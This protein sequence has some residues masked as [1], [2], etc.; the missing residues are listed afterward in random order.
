MTKDDGMTI[1]TPKRKRGRPKGS[2]DSYI[3]NRSYTK[4]PPPTVIEGLM[5]IIYKLIREAQL[6]G[7]LEQTGVN[8][9]GA[10]IDVD[11]SIADL[12]AKIREL[13]DS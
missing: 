3:R 2:T 5:P 13:L 4:R 6:V 1:P 7:S 8:T 11:K 9:R 10:Q 12:L